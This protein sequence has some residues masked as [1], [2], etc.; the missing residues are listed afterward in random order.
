M[1]KKLLSNLLAVIKTAHE[2]SENNN[3][4]SCMILGTS[5]MGLSQETCKTIWCVNCIYYNNQRRYSEVVKIIE[6]AV[7]VK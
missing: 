7:H 3:E 1:N 5:A 2:Y 4:T 6:D